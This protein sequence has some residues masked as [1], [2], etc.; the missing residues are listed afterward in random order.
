MDARAAMSATIQ[1][2]VTL[3]K[4]YGTIPYD[5][6]RYSLRTTGRSKGRETHNQFADAMSIAPAYTC[7]KLPLE[8]QGVMPVAK[9][10]NHRAWAKTIKTMSRPWSGSEVHILHWRC[11]STKYCVDKSEPSSIQGISPLVVGAF[12]GLRYVRLSGVR[13]TTLIA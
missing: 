4:K 6:F 7:I 13:S 9:S 10:P 2:K 8:M 3:A 11:K 1:H 5:P 12:R